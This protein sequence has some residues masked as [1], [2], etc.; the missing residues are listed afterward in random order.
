MLGC[1]VGAVALKLGLDADHVPRL[2]TTKP[3]SE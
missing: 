3:L 2:C 1:L